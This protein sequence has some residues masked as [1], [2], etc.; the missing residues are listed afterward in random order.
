MGSRAQELAL[1]VVYESPLMCVADDPGHYRNQPGL[2]FLRVVPTVWDETKVLDGAVGKHIVIARRLGQD[3]YLGG[4]TAD[5]AYALQ[6]PLG[7][8]GSGSYTVRIFAD[9]TDPKASYEQLT[10]T[11]QTLTSQSTLT[12]NMRPAGG[13]AVYFKHK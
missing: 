9:P 8:L 5:D 4:I 3:W 6:L 13:V 12:L 7:F 11:Q 2:D 10:D 1:L